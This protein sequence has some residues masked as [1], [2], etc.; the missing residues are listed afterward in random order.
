MVCCRVLRIMSKAA[1]GGP[2]QT[3]VPRRLLAGKVLPL[4][5]SEEPAW[6]QGRCLV[7]LPAAWPPADAKHDIV[8]LGVSCC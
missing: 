3:S 8:R 6:L 4:L 1:W 7:P 2:E 5:D